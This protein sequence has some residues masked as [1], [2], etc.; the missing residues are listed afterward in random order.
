MLLNILKEQIRSNII[1]QI[2]Q[3][4]MISVIIDSRIVITD[5]FNLEQFTFIARY[6][7]K[8]IIQE[9]LVALVT[10]SDGTGQGLFNVFCKITDK[11]NLIWQIHYLYAQSYDGA[12]LMH[13]HWTVLCV[14]SN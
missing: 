8:G 5:I 6:V 11:Y 4:Q 3:S 1:D 13:G 2:K 9:H 12:V 14:D 7:H 10:A